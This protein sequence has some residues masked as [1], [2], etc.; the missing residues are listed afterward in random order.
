MGTKIFISWSGDRSR[1]VAN[2]LESW[3]REVIQSLEP[4]VST[5]MDK[6][7]RWFE[8]IH[9]ELKNTALGIICLT[10]ENKDNPWILYESG[11]LANRLENNSVFTFLFDV[12]LMQIANPLGQFNHT[13]YSKDEMLKLIQ[14]INKLIDVPLEDKILKKSFERSWEDLNGNLK[15]IR[16]TKVD[17]ALVGKELND[18]DI[19]SDLVQSVREIESHIR[20]VSYGVMSI[21]IAP[22]TQDSQLNVAQMIDQ[23]TTAL[24]CAVTPI[25]N[26]ENVPNPEWY[27]MGHVVTFVKKTV[28][29]ELF[30]L[31]NIVSKYGWSIRAA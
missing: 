24:E 27:Q 2:L 3:L 10:P 16:E 7:V 21:T 11:A 5:K 12:D 28:P 29:E 13:L 17:E 22:D 8:E 31:R 15:R 26:I 19:L 18:K 25:G 6:G 20:R 30:V 9:A 1:E 23:I 14:S 4:Y